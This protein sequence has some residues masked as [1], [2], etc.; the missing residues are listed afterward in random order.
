MIFFLLR[1]TFPVLL[2][3][4]VPSNRVL[5]VAT[6]LVQEAFNVEGVVRIR[7]LW[8]VYSRWIMASDV[9]NRISSVL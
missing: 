8:V 1:W 5:S 6:A 9:Y 7:N 3:P 2:L 4:G